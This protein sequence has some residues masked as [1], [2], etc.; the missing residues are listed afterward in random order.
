MEDVMDACLKQRGC[1]VHTMLTAYKRLLKEK[2]DAESSAS[3]EEG[4]V[5][6]LDDGTDHSVA[7]ALPEA[8]RAANL[9]NDQRHAFD[10]MVQYNPADQMLPKS[11]Q[12]HKHEQ[13]QVLPVSLT[14]HLNSPDLTLL[15][16]SLPL[17]SVLY[18]H[19]G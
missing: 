5:D 2:V 11:S 6:L 10:K 3:E 12:Q 17:S 9:L 14:N 7:A 19:Q 8:A 15:P 4:E 16:Y 13:N 18:T 1:Q